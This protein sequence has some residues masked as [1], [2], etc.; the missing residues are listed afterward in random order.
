MNAI[1][2]M[3]A[4]RRAL[5]VVA[6]LSAGTLAAQAPPPAQS[7]PPVQAETKPAPPALADPLAQFDWLA[8]CWRGEFNRREFREHWMPVRGGMLVGMS[9]TVSAGKTLS[10]EYLRIERRADG[11]YYVLRS[12]PASESVLKLDKTTVEGAATIFTFANPALEFPRQLSYRRDPGEWL[13]ATVTGKV[14]GT[15]RD[16]VYAMRRIDCETGDFINP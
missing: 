6:L 7:V 1:N 13:Y 5:A 2:A 8:G 15:D 12:G 9:Q 4:T 14:S 11:I 3:R 10:Y 16:L